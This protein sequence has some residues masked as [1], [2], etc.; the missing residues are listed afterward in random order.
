[1]SMPMDTQAAKTAMDPIDVRIIGGSPSKD[2][3]SD[4]GSWKTFS[5]LAGNAQGPQQILP[6]DRNRS[7]ARVLVFNGTGA[8]AGAFVLL[9]SRGQI[10]NNQGGTILGGTS[11]TVENSQELWM[12]GDGTNAMTVTVLAERYAVD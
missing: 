7:K 5:V 3:A 1:M 2:L 4:F 11:I 12:T 9:G 10:Q 6:V 8:A